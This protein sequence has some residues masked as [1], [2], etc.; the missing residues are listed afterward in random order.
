MAVHAVDI[1]ESAQ[2]VA[3]LPQAL[4]G[5]TRA[6]ATTARVRSLATQLETPHGT[7]LVTRGT[8][9]ALILVQNTGAE[10]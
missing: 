3:T 10:Q 7:T 6:I 1:L 8:G 5:C 9:A 2:R 4:Q